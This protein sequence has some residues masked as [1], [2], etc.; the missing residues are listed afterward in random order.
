ML[1]KSFISS[2]TISNKGDVQFDY[3]WSFGNNGIEKRVSVDEGP[4]TAL[5]GRPVSKQ[6]TTRPSTTLTGT[7]SVEPSRVMAA[8]K[9]S[10]ERPTSALAFAYETASVV[11]ESATDLFP[12]SIEPEIGSIPAGNNAKFVAKFAPMDVV[13]YSSCLVCR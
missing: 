5:D 3:H 9:L 1:I 6:Q 8:S 4:P 10:S 13:D 12:F 11:S 2:F 7:S